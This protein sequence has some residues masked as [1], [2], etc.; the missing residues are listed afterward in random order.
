ME[1]VDE[2]DASVCRDEMNQID[3]GHQR[4]LS[5]EKKRV[6]ATIGELGESG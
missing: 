4:L 3:F 6:L 1:T 2:N 5:C